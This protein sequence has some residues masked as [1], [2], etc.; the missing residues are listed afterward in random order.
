MNC[1]RMVLNVDVLLQVFSSADD[2]TR[3]ALLS[4]CHAFYRAGGKQFL[5]SA[6]VK[7]DTERRA[8]SFHQFVKADPPNRLP[9]SSNR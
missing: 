8:E 4:T 5:K 9:Y 1:D 2:Q 6:D 3:L 7:L